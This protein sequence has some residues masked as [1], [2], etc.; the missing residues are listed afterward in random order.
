MA[1]HKAKPLGGIP[2]NYEV[3]GGATAPTTFNKENTIWIDTAVNK[4]AIAKSQARKNCAKL[5]CYINTTTGVV[6]EPKSNTCY[7]KYFFCTTGHEYNFKLS[8]GQTVLIAHFNTMPSK[9][10]TGTI[11]YGEGKTT[12]LDELDYTVTAPAGLEVNGVT[13]P[14][15]LAIYY[16]DSSAN[17]S[18][19]ELVIT[20]VTEM[21]NIISELPDEYEFNEHAFAYEN[22][23]VYYETIDYIADATII[24]DKYLSNTNVVTTGDGDNAPCYTENYIPV[25]YG[26]VYN[27][28]YT[29]STSK[30]MWLRILEYTSTTASNSDVSYT[31]K[32]RDVPINSVPGTSQTLTYTPSSSDVAAVRLSWRTFYPLGTTCNFSFIESDEHNLAS[33]GSLWIQTDIDDYSAS[34]NAIKR[35]ELMIY[36]KNCKLWSGDRWMRMGGSMLY[37]GDNSV[38]LCKGYELIKDSVSDAGALMAVYTANQ[39]KYTEDSGNSGFTLKATSGSNARGVKIVYINSDICGYNTISVAGNFSA[40]DA[41]THR[42]DIDIFVGTLAQ[43]STIDYYGESTD[44][45]A[46]SIFR[47]EKIASGDIN[48]ENFDISNATHGASEPVY[49]AIRCNAYDGSSTQIHLTDITLD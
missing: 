44:Y 30:S 8:D 26:T 47:G 33:E 32:V 13:S 43:I 37:M 35:N 11:L 16:Y 3:V 17:S 29:L 20:D 45:G 40:T 25:K 41:T 39:S 14:H 1:T 5:D 36:P 23:W 22:P 42:A 24:Q 15:C 2:L 9:G 7:T 6:T 49:I 27:I 31:F 46:T 28:N 10:S 18:V 34:F 48:I 4:E 19:P 38:K 12:G 21:N